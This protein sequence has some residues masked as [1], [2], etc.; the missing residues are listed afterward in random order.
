MKSCETILEHQ[1]TYRLIYT[2][3]LRWLT[4]LWILLT[5]CYTVIVTVSFFQPYW[6]SSGPKSPK[7]ATLGL[8]QVCT[9]RNLEYNQFEGR[10]IVEKCIGDLPSVL[11]IQNSS[12]PLLIDQ[13]FSVYNQVA[14]ISLGVAA[15]A[16][17]VS[18]FS[19]LLF[20]MCQ[21]RLVFGLCFCLQMISCKFTMLFVILYR[22][23]FIKFI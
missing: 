12:S 16:A 23:K 14:V 2:K 13:Y 10:E 6:L 11:K 19:V 17:L 4:I 8:Y 21:A 9:Y 5:V 3:N 1:K 18:L 7:I 15:L 22:E 20:F